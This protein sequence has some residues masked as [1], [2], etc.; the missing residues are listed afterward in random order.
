MILE[1]A[2]LIFMKYYLMTSNQV[3]INI[4][5]IAMLKMMQKNSYKNS[6]ITGEDESQCVHMFK[7]RN[8]QGI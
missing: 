3:W 7:C 1:L 4:L 6:E 8:S 5:V 2:M